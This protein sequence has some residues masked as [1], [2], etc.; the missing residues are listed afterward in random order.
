MA[1]RVLMP[2]ASGGRVRGRP[3][4]GLMDGV[5][6]ALGNRGM[7][8][9]VHII[10]NWVWVLIGHFCLARCSFGPP[11]GC[12]Y[13]EWLCACYLARHDYPSLVEGESHGILLFW[14]ILVYFPSRGSEW[15]IGVG[16]V[17]QVINP[18]PWRDGISPS[19]S[20]G[21][22]D[23]VFFFCPLYLFPYS[24]LSS[25]LL[26]FLCVFHSCCSHARTFGK[27]L[28]HELQISYSYTE[29]YLFFSARATPS[30]QCVIRAKK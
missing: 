18:L 23:F 14:L 28:V 29:S 17:R 16:E 10:C 11:K 20:L 9:L 19:Y 30:A 12:T 26:L 21:S 8:V 7:A 13:V 27:T 24:L 6:V 3:R 25:Y 22:Q 2:E 1:R 5:R 15:I 4:L